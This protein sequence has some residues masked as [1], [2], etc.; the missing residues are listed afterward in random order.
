MRD[1]AANVGLMGLEV[2]SKLVALG[3]DSQRYA[4]VVTLEHDSQAIDVYQQ[5]KARARTRARIG[6]AG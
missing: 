5:V 2:L 3:E 6:L 4:L 1:V